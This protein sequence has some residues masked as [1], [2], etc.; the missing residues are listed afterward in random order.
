MH[1]LRCCRVVTYGVS[2]VSSESR[3]T[4]GWGW[5]TQYSSHRKSTN[6]FCRNTHFI[7]KLWKSAGLLLNTNF[8]LLRFGAG[9]DCNGRCP[10]FDCSFAG[11]QSPESPSTHNQHAPI[12]YDQLQHQMSSDGSKSLPH[13]SPHPLKSFSVPGPP[14]P[15]HPQHSAPNTP[16]PKHIGM[17]WG[18]Y[19]TCWLPLLLH[20]QLY[21]RHCHRLAMLF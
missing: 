9:L 11:P 12:P 15:T 17:A 16:T 7:I 2:P 18:C 19:A 8:L 5:E 13:R 6:H 4:Y 21:F 20:A 10:L 14:P 3:D 1:C